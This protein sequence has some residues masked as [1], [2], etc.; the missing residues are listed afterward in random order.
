MKL[1]NPELFVLVSFFMSLNSFEIVFHAPYLIA[2]LLL[3]HIISSRLSGF[4]TS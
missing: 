1:G 2:E 4:Q 3:Q